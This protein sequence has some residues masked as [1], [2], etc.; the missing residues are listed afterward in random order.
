VDEL[1][2]KVVE[3]TDGPLRNRKKKERKKRFQS[4]RPERRSKKVRK[5]LEK[6]AMLE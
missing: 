1:K 3:K 2:G 5:P 6:N 4:K